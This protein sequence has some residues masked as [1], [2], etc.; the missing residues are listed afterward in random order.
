[1]KEIINQATRDKVT[2]Y[3]FLASIFVLVLTV[4]VILINY[5]KLPPLVPI[6][7]QLPWGPQR[8]TPT[9]GIF[10]PI[11]LF[12]VLLVF[13][14]SFSSFLYLKNNPLLGRI[15]ASVTLLLSIMNLI[16]IIRTIILVT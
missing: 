4:L 15:I 5:L 10:I 16:F 1:M 3:L 12:L 9:L 7:N 6:F 14:L 11:L 13:N 2:F 8:L